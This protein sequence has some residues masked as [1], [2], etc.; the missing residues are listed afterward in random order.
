MDTFFASPEKASAEDLAAEVGF[1]C[2]NS[3]VTGLLEITDGLL[4]VLNEHRQIIALNEA[5]LE[6]LGITDQKEVLG[7]RPGEALQCI[8]GNDEPAGCGTTRWCSSCGAAIAIAASLG[9]DKPVERTCVLSA[10]SKGEQTDIVLKV[11][12][13]PVRLDN[14][15]FLL[16]FLQ[17]RTKEQQ[18]A[19]LERV[20]FHDINNI[21]N[22]LVVAS[23][24][25]EQR[26]PSDL[27]RTIKKAS[28]RLTQEITFQQYLAGIET[29][30]Y[31]PHWQTVSPVQ[32][33]EEIESLFSGHPAAQNK[34]IE[35]TK[36]GR[37]VSITTDIS[38]LSRILS[39]MVI[40]ALE[41]T[42]ERGLVRIWTLR[43]AENLT[44]CVW[45]A[46]EIP[47]NLAPRIFQR[48][49]STKGQEGRGIGTFSMKFFGETILGGKVAFATS[50]E[51]GTV[52]TFSLPL[53]RELG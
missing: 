24:L 38:V 53:S 41:A 34:T 12:S 32:V 52:F 37:D 28:L 47:E 42:E 29:G 40:N 21:I 30:I 50:R 13:Q 6:A 25:L 16:L 9:G 39:N 46:M 20:F 1:V 8:H 45:N 44:F 22:V 18:R 15:R 11:K 4:A 31:G 7:L 19:T 3:I 35:I 36:D 2:H 33:I 26:S 17:D 49:F 43:D 48:N 14:R 27:A 5:L 10:K 23:E 51:G